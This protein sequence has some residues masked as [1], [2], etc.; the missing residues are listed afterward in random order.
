MGLVEITV[1]LP[2]E[3]VEEACEFDLLTERKLA[4]VLRSE[5]DRRVMEMVNAEIQAYRAEKAANRS[6][7]SFAA[8]C[9]MFQ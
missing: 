9:S 7:D 3:L 8:N 4:E 5:V 6:H 2:E 1:K